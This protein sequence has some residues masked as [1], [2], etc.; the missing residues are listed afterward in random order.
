MESKKITSVNPKP[1]PNFYCS[2]DPCYL[3][4]LQALACCFLLCTTGC[5]WQTP[6]KKPADGTV[7]KVGRVDLPPLKIGM[8]DCDEVA[9]SLQS[10]WQEFS[11]Q[12]LELVKLD[13]DKLSDY[14]MPLLDV[15]LYP[16][17]L[18]GTLAE[19]EWIA[20]VP[21]PLLQRLGGG[22]KIGRS[23]QEPA[24]DTVQGI[25]N[26]SSRLRSIAKYNGKWMGIPLGGPCW[27][28]ATRGLDVD[29]LKQL[30]QAIASNQNTPNIATE[31]FEAFLSKTESTLED[32]L[33]S[34][35]KT[36]AAALRDRKAT[37]KRALVN[38]FLWIMITTESRYRGLVDPYKVTPRLAL[39]EF[40]RSAR[41]LQRLAL[42]EPT[43]I[44]SSPVEAWE[45]VAE[46]QAVIGIGW[47][48]S[49][50]FQR[51]TVGSDVK[52]L[53]LIPIL[54]NG[55]DGILASIGRKTR[56]SSMASE[57]MFWLNREENRAALQAKTPRVEVLEIENDSNRIREDY[58][59][60]QT[61]Q[62]LEASNT[63]LDMTARFLQADVFVDSLG[64]ALLDILEKP[65]LADSRLEACKTKWAE[66]IDSIGVESLRS[67]LERATGLSN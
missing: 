62:R 57:F 17:S 19:K 31:A 46:G 15:I 37:D 39:P 55:A 59:E 48:R 26:W 18:V 34:R 61:L 29:A 50:G 51:A 13:P 66:L 44:L 52:T 2:F 36:L 22:K 12:Q 60:Y 28:V 24:E 3:K 63:T 25:E 54:F 27:V 65:E 38:R 16:A 6:P 20:P 5:P 45:K 64:E 14:E 41:Y 53:K 9:D 33:E 32:S 11:E 43:T 4:I 40:A 21:P 7:E 42:I 8:F 10:R 67:S 30:Q 58:R 49:D 1:N 23:N 56:Q 35:R 47:P